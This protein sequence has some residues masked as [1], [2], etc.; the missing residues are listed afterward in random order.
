VQARLPAID[1]EVENNP[2]TTW[3]RIAG[4]RAYQESMKG[5]SINEQ[6]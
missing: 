3:K 2:K 6:S 5:I 1:R 4:D